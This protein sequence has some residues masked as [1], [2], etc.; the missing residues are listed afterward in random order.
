MVFR[1]LLFLMALLPN[2]SYA[3][4]VEHWPTGGWLYGEPMELGLDADFLNAA[5]E[6]AQQ[7]LPELQTLTVVRNGRIAFEHLADGAAHDRLT[8]VHSVTKSITAI[9]FG[10]AQ[11]EGGVP[12]L[13]TP[14]SDIF[15]YEFQSSPLTES[16]KITV[17]DL[18]TMQAGFAWED[19]G[20]VFWRWRYSKDRFHAA[21]A[22]E[23]RH[24]PGEVFT[25]STAV[26]HL[27][28]G[29]MYHSGISN[30]AD[31]AQQ[32]LF[33]PL[34]I[35]GFRWDKD[36][37]GVHTG[38][39][40]LQLTPHSMAKIG[41]LLLNN[42]QW[43]GKQVLP[44]QWVTA[45]TSNHIRSSAGVGYG[46]QWWIKDVAGCRSFRAWGR[47]GQFIVVVPEK[48]LIVVTTAT[49]HIHTQNSLAF[50]PMFEQIARAAEG[51]CDPDATILAEAETE[52]EREVNGVQPGAVDPPDEIVGFFAEF[53]SAILAGD[54]EQLMSFYSDD[55]LMNGVTKSERRAFWG[56]VIRSVTD[57]SIQISDWSLEGDTFQYDG[58]VSGSFGTSP[59]SGVLRKENGRWVTVG[60]QLASAQKT[61]IPVD[62]QSFLESYAADLPGGE[63]LVQYFADDFKSNGFNRQEFL[64][65]L[66]P[67]RGGL[68]KISVHV[69]EIEQVDD[70]TIIRG[71]LFS[72]TL[73]E[74]P[75]WPIYYAAIFVDGKWSWYGNQKDR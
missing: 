4:E 39:T 41:L 46:F 3:A 21:L 63:S 40:G 22:L 58:V 9:L 33:A 55:F 74:L 24:L 23:Q 43:D 18:L 70:S 35:D 31:Y 2:L 66:E 26:S 30:L 5:K 49:P 28:S 15:P 25:Y 17:H 12:G 13:K 51:K 73:G 54:V 44:E 32:K 42:G 57:F 34:G 48:D 38:G 20:D 1:A 8:P 45:T 65:F 36:P 11:S 75:I 56:K 50:E 62:L 47:G 69:S 27:I 37:L 6:Y 29:A 19:R 10:I 14:A 72:E 60:N 16:G 67:F 68:G 61:H 64:T 53:S 52:E 59:T 71:H 7:N